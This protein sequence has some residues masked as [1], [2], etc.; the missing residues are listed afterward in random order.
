MGII[1]QIIVLFIVLSSMVMVLLAIRQL[2][3]FE[4][5]DDKEETNGLRDDVEEKKNVLSNNSIF[6][7]LVEVDTDKREK[8][9]YK[10]N[11]KGPFSRKE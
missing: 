2:S 8:R 7:T 6:S 4:G 9:D 10:S 3:R 1:T 11:S 5:F